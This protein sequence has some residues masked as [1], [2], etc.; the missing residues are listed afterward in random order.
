MEIEITKLKYF[1]T[2][3]HMR[4]I[5]RAA[6]HLNITQPSLSASLRRLENEIGFQLF[7]RTGRTIQLN[8][9]GKLFLDGVIAAKN[10]MSACLNEMEE[11]RQSSE[12]FVRLVCSISVTNS[13]LIDLLLSKG[14][15]LKMSTIPDNW[16]YELA[17]NNCDL[18]ITMGRSQHAGIDC[19]ILRNY[20][21]AFVASRDHP[22]A[23]AGSLTMNDLRRYPFCSTSAPHSL[24][25][26]AKAQLQAADFS[27]RISFLG[28]DSADM[29]KA[30]RSGKYIGL[31]VVHHLPASEDFVILP[32][33]D[34]SVELPIHLYWR[35]SD[36]KSSSLASLRQSIVDFY[37]GLSIP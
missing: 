14:E 24:I 31:M 20:K 27:P 17:N 9:Y 29:V 8:E 35:K 23:G 21:I 36:S 19:M 5:T 7:D 2:V 6:H 34:F 10:I 16:E 3:A 30:I 13:K 22:L 28:R 33:E 4:H 26:M 25:N 15:K 37:Q 12:S 18:V 32:V 11:L 1:V